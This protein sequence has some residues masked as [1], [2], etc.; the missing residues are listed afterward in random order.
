MKEM[1]KLYAKTATEVSAL[2]WLHSR[3]VSGL[4]QTEQNV[5]TNK[6][7][8]TSYYNLSKD[9]PYKDVVDVN[10]DHLTDLHK[11][12]LK[13][14]K[15]FVGFVTLT[16]HLILEWGE[17]SYVLKSEY[18]DYLKVLENL[19]IS[20][21]ENLKVTQLKLAL[22]YEQCDKD[23]PNDEAFK[24]FSRLNSEYKQWSK[25]KHYVMIVENLFLKPDQ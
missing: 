11:L 5:V 9:N 25:H 16:K 2:Q 8:L 13:C 12:V 20:I 3:L 4:K 19:K 1:Y 15:M 22:A 6:H 23:N 21:T 17:G 14:R 24:E 18:E 7:R 10:I